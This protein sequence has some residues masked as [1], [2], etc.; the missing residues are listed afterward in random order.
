MTNDEAQ[1]TKKSLTGSSFVIRHSTLLL[2][3]ALLATAIT[4]PGCS[5]TPETPQQKAAREKKE[6]EQEQK[7]LEEEKARKEGFQVGRPLPQPNQEDQPLMLVKP[8]HWTTA[9]QRMKASAE[10]WVGETSL[11]VVD[12]QGQ[13]IAVEQTGFALQSSRNA[14]V[15]KGQEKQIETVLYVP[16]QDN[17]LRAR[18]EVR[19]R[20]SGFG[21]PVD[22]MP[23]L[24][25]RPHQY[26]FVV[27]A[28]ERQRYGFVNTLYSVRAPLSAKFDLINDAMRYP[29][30]RQ[31]RVV[32]PDTE[33]R[34]PVPDNPLCWTSVA[35]LL[36][37]EIDPERLEPAQRQ[38][39][40]DWLHWGG[41]LI[42]S[43]PDSLDLLA[44][45]FLDRYL[46]ADNQ[47]ARKISADDLQTLAA[48]WGVG[49][50]G[51]PLSPTVDW[52]GIKLK[53]RKEAEPVIDMGNL[54][55]ERQVGRGRIIVSA[56]QLAERDLVNWSGG[57]DNLFN[58]L[59]MRR[60]PRKFGWQESFDDS[61]AYVVRPR[62][63]DSSAVTAN[64]RLRY[65]GRDTHQNI[66]ALTYDVV[67]TNEGAG[68]GG[69]GMGFGAQAN[70]PAV[71]IGADFGTRR[72]SSSSL[73]GGLGAWN[74]F[75]AASG[76]A[77]AS[78]RKAAGVSVPGSSFVVTCLAIYLT[79]LVPFNW[80]VFRALGRV[81]LAWV[82]APL[83][84]L[85]GTVAVV[86]QAQLDI[87]FVRAQTEIA[88]L[89]LQPEH[90]RGVLTRFHSF[91]T[92]L[93]TTYELAFDKPTALAAP[94]SASGES[95]L[96]S[97]QSPATVQYERQETARLKGLAV[98]SNTTGMAHSEQ[99]FDL[100]GALRFDADRKM[101]VNETDYNIESVALVRRPE[102]DL[103]GGTT[104]QGCWIGTLA[105]RSS[106][107]ASFS[108]LGWDDEK[109]PLFE[110]RAETAQEEQLNLEQLFKLALDP[111]RI[112]PGEVRLVGRVDQI[113]PGVE[114]TPKAS[115]FRGATLVLAHL[116]Y[117]PLP[118]PKN[119]A[120]A[121]VDVQKEEKR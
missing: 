100:G 23:L 22:M 19:E 4:I 99:M 28:K 38:A 98:S 54:F 85:L 3:V 15:G 20:G 65:F 59:I 53:P 92:S 67:E 115:Q 12:K 43:G 84:A 120:N 56:M 50:K 2:L 69:M 83:I 121:P 45:S 110:R 11:Q 46:P 68:F 44:D 27:L 58:S 113:L 10:D 13:P 107:P 9:T 118:A 105:A 66:D 62:T 30:D 102:R 74:D 14:A 82:T 116:N 119:D 61:Y 5:C 26:H 35:Y 16:P 73:V 78:L 57:F 18:S 108:P 40:V 47:G 34:I 104:L 33:L 97:G 8:G 91:Y 49:E 79:V 96:L 111:K 88:M 32:A 29:F 39:L 95:P 7:R 52:S 31:Y 63:R 51:K 75:N 17:S 42:V 101:L 103:R 72:I 76:A 6:A 94:F 55:A 48:G 24:R 86:K 37:D 90:P 60:P 81:E 87:G 89:E 1:M 114:V 80:L 41:Q 70:Q 109:A 64:T 71:G 112:E 117:P 106:T 93:S 77:R 21:L 36:W 25:M